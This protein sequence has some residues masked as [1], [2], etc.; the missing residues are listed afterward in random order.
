MDN[1]TSQHIILVND[2]LNIYGVD[3]NS[4]KERY[5]TI[6]ENKRQKVSFSNIPKQISIVSSN[7]D[8]HKEERLNNQ[9]IKAQIVPSL[10][11]KVRHELVDVLYTYKNVFSSDNKPLGAFKGL[12]VDITLNIDRPYL[13]V[14]KGKV[15]PASPRAREAFKKHIQEFIP[16]GVLRKAGHNEEVEVETPF[17]FALHN[18][19]SRMVG[20]FR[21]LN[22]YT[23]TDRYTIPRIQEALAHLSKPKYIA[24]MDEL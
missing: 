23:I 5:F 3:I 1:C 17:I 19:N 6:G 20:Y 21:A 15:Y 11:Q 12:E 16:L 14:L 7:Q 24:S 13:P 4:H 18:D 10:S 2:Y 9:P 8:T 22:T